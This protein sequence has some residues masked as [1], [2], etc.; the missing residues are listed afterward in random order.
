MEDAIPVCLEHLGVR[1]ETGVA[2]FSDL[3]RQEL[4]S[5]CGVAEDDGLVDLQLGR[6]ISLNLTAD[7]VAH[8]GKKG[9]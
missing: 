6:S 2:E 1:V 3:L 9:V 8:F 7:S 5:V 4:D